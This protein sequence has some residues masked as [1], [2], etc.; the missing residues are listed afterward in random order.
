M[1][2]PAGRRGVPERASPHV[3]HPRLLALDTSTPR[4]VLAV[5]G[6]DGET[7]TAAPDPAVRHG[8]VLVPAVRALLA[9]AR[10]TLAELDGLV[11]GLGPGSYTGLRIGLTAVKT[12][13]Y[14][15]HKP[16]AGLDSLDIVARNAPAAARRVAVIADAQ[17]GDL[18]VADFI[19]EAPGAVPVRVVP[20][21]IE[22]FEAWAAGLAEETLVL[23]P[24]ATLERVLAHLPATARLPNNPEAHW[25]DPHR[26][27]ELALEVWQSGRRDDPWFLEPVYL[28][29]SA[30][31]EQWDRKA[32]GG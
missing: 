20:T 29:R 3:T 32:A 12:L 1:N 18:Y 27:A 13:A 10:L 21:R 5:T 16:L 15:A 26:L 9:A 30:A 17:R 24:A 23:G 7:V 31:E 6:A 4:A 14:A 22:P 19:R 28:R 25:P 11:V 8:R 2:D